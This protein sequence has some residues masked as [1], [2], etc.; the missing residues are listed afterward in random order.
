MNHPLIHAQ[1]ARTFADDVER[2]ARAPRL[3]PAR[4]R[5]WRQTARRIIHALPVP[6]PR[7]ARA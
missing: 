2:R 3:A 1:L 4:R 6:V 5:S 7:A